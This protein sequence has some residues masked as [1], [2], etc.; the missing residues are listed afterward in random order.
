MGVAVFATELL[1]PAEAAVVA[2]VDVRDVN[3]VFDER[4]LP[5]EFVAVDGGRRVTAA[6]CIFISFYFDTANALTSEKRLSTI[7]VA[8]LR[9]AK[10]RSKSMAGLAK[11]DWTVRDDLL[12]IDLAPYWKRT[13]EQFDRLTAARNLI[14]TDPDVLG[15]APVIRG[16]RVPVY[17]VAA[18]VAAGLTKDRIRKAYPSLDSDKIELAVIYAKANPVRGRPRSGKELPKGA[19]IVDDRRVPRR[20][21]A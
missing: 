9:F 8:G 21:K 20:G 5:D 16:T 18:S 7:R 4:I 1:K 15:G 19:R 2:R 11:E 10:W 3:R 13:W 17:D 6:A 14:E 12:T